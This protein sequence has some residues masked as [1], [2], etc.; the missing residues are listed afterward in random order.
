MVHPGFPPSDRTS[1]STAL[2]YSN[3]MDTD[4]RPWAGILNDFKA[5]PPARGKT[6]WS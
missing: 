5:T 2:L 1:I 4:W 3:K 6:F